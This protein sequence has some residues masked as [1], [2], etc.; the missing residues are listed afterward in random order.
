MSKREQILA[1]VVTALAGTTGVGSRI[2]RSREDALDAAESPSLIVMPDSEEPQELT[3]G[4][5]EAKLQFSV[6]VFA[7][8]VSAPDTT[9]DATAESV[10]AKLLAAPTLG[11]LAIDLSEAG[12]EW[13]FDQADQTSV[14]VRMR[15]VAWYRHA[16]ASLA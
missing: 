14:I 6:H 8:A 2:F 5:V 4:L 15:F 13:D 11:G 3:N 16:R 1:A 7:R 10:H 12:T 9:A